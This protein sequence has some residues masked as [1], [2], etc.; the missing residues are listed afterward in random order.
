MSDTTPRG[1]SIPSLIN[2]L[3]HPYIASLFRHNLGDSP[4]SQF[5]MA[6]R[7]IRCQGARS[8]HPTLPSCRPAERRSCD[9]FG[10]LS[11]LV[12]PERNHNNVFAHISG[13]CWQMGLAKS[14]QLAWISGSAVCDVSRLVVLGILLAIRKK[15]SPSSDAI[16]NLLHHRGTGWAHF[17]QCSRTESLMECGRTA[18]QSINGLHH[19]NCEKPS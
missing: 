15:S 12:R 13:I 14:A 18:H 19:L 16:C 2:S 3:H 9:G 1:H 17:T 7:R 11:L 8:P 6:P 4:G 5:S 10:R